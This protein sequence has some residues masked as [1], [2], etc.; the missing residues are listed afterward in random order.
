MKHY[1]ILLLAIINPL[2]SIFTD[3]AGVIQLASGIFILNLFLEFGRTTNLVLIACLRG[4]GDVFYPTACAVFSN[5]L[6]SVGGSYVLAVVCGW[7]LYGLWIALAAD[8]CFR[9]LLMILRWCGTRWR[10]AR[11]G[12]TAPSEEA[13][14]EAFPEN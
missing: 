8:E 4:A 7:G 1:L 14:D 10:N 11:L 13:S 9:G 6:L 2:I 3:N 5:W 12:Q